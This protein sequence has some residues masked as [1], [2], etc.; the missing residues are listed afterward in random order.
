[1]KTLIALVAAA[2][3]S[4]ASAIK[5]QAQ[6][7]ANLIMQARNMVAT[8]SEAYTHLTNALGFPLPSVAAPKAGPSSDPV[9]RRCRDDG[10]AGWSTNSSNHR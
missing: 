1:M 4:D 5:S 9:R 2:F 7:A 8:N 3:V 6:A 10:A